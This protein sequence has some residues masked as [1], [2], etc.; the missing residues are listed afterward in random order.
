MLKADSSN[1]RT[2]ISFPESFQQ[3]AFLQH[4]GFKDQ[5]SIDIDVMGHNALLIRKAQ[6]SCKE[7]VGGL[8]FME[9]LANNT[10]SK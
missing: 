6:I 8:H 2:K 4:V 3:S 7:N 9:Y 1:P 5:V 10:L